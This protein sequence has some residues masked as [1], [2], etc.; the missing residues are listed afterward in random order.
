MLPDELLGCFRYTACCFNGTTHVMVGSTC[1]AE[2]EQ[3]KLLVVKVEDWVLFQI[4]CLVVLQPA[5]RVGIHVRPMRH[6]VEEADQ[7]EQPR[8]RF[9]HFKRSN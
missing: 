2:D 5:E 4:N 7:L 6:N 8:V 1:R 9:V 3:P